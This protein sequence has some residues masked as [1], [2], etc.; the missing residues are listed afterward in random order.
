MGEAPTYRAGPFRVAV[1]G[2]NEITVSHAA[3]FQTKFLIIFFDVFDFSTFFSFDIFRFDHICFD[4]IF[5]DIFHFRPFYF[6][7]FDV[8]RELKRFNLFYYQFSPKCC[9]AA[10]KILSW[11]LRS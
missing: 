3:L 9:A 11:V 8:V 5:F 10:F 7:R 2:L 6:R 4:I 1:L